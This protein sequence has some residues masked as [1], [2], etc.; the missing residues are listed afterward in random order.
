MV[1][2]FQFND[3][4]RIRPGSLESDPGRRPQMAKEKNGV[5][6]RSTRLYR[7]IHF[8][9]MDKALQDIATEFVDSFELVFD[10]DWDHTVWTIKNPEHFIEGTFL[11]PNVQD[12]YNDWANRGNLLTAYRKLKALLVERGEV[13]T[14]SE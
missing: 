7:L 12:E 2:V 4:N 14:L 10:N 9:K 6:I 11:R 1:V 8:S 3:P 13:F 5:V